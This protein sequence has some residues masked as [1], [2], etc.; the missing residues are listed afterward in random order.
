MM[1]QSPEG[2]STMTVDRAQLRLSYAGQLAFAQ[3][4]FRFK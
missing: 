3:Y 2:G 1:R 4:E